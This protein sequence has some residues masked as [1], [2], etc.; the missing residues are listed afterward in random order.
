[1]L[2]REKGSKNN[3]NSTEKGSQRK[4]EGPCNTKV[5]GLGIV[6]LCEDV[7][8]GRGAKVRVSLRKNRRNS[9]SKASW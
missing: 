1:M 4:E 5:G 8:E 2:L 6:H 3:K 7:K 9:L